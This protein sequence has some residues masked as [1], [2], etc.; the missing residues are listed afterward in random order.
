MEGERCCSK[1]V[2][3]YIYLMWKYIVINV[4][5]KNGIEWNVINYLSK[6]FSWVRKGTTGRRRLKA[7]VKKLL[8]MIWYLTTL[9]QV[10]MM[11]KYLLLLLKLELL[12]QLP[13]KLL[14]LSCFMVLKPVKH[15]LAFNLSKMRKMGSDVL[16]L[17]SIRSSNS[18]PIHFLQ[19]HQLLRRWAPSCGSCWRHYESKLKGFWDVCLC[20]RLCVWQKA[21]AWAEKV[22]KWE[23]S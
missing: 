11:L 17:W 9:L 13:S 22:M 14:P 6:N 23:M 3:F 8:V 18:T 21:R 12:S 1:H 20:V 7:A 4:L 5:Y 16:N 19:N 10:M 15:I 2:L